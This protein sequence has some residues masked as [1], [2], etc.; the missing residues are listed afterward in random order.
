MI[1]HGDCNCSGAFDFADINAFVAI[2]E[3]ESCDPNCG[4]RDS[5]DP[6]QMTPLE[7]AVELDAHVLPGLRPQLRAIIAEA[8]PLFERPATGAYWHAVRERLPE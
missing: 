6:P 5:E 7:L 2:I 1:Y 8:I 4:Q 3:G